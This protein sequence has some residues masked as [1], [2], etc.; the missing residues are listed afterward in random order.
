MKQLNRK[1]NGSHETKILRFNGKQ[2]LLAQ[3]T[4]AAVKRYVESGYAG[5]GGRQMA[6]ISRTNRD[7][8][9]RLETVLAGR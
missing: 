4:S 6:I 3:H 2:H 5:V 1:V 7:R 9:H 8:W